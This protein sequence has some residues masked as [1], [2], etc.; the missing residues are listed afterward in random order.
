MRKYLSI[1]LIVALITVLIPAPVVQAEVADPL[2]LEVRSAVLME[3]ETGQILYTKNEDITLPPASVTKVMTMLVIMDAIEKGHAS[4]DDVVTTSE[5]AHNMTGSQVFLAIGEKASL[6]DMFE[7]I[8]V[9]SANDCAVALAEHIAGSEEIFVNLMNEKARELGLRNTRYLNVTGFPYIEQY[10]NFNEPDGHT[11]SAL[12]IAII[13]RELVKNYP[14]V[15]EFTKIPFATFKNGV[16]MPTRNNIMLRNDWIDG[17]KTGFTNEAKFCLSASGEKNGVRFISVILGAENDRARQDETL[18]LLNYGYNNFDKVT[19]ILGKEDIMSVRIEK[20]K[21]REVALIAAESLNLVVEKDA[22][23]TYT[24]IIEINENIVAPI[25]A[26]TVLGQLYYVKDGTLIGSPINLVAK[27]E[28]EKGGFFR[29]LS[30]G[31]KD[32]FFGIFEGVADKILSLFSKQ[33]KES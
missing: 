26:N 24:Q 19:M 20:G 32:T 17:L 4:W 1:V 31:I 27:D 8:A 9:Y 14:E 13:S 6:R 25:E 22:A 21:E 11:M 29:L 18:K 28:V 7:A 16:N 33:T 23:D 15:L 12:D 3:V 2:N 5:K 10:P 30:R